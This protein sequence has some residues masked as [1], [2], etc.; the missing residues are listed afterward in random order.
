M[1]FNMKFNAQLFDLIFSQC[2]INKRLFTNLWSLGSRRSSPSSIATLLPTD[3]LDRFTLIRRWCWTKSQS[4]R[5]NYELHHVNL[6][7]IDIG[8]FTFHCEMCFSLSSLNVVFSTHYLQTRQNVIGIEIEMRC[9]Q[10]K[11]YEFSPRVTI[12]MS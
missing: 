1:F 8:F 3:K 6:L 9:S 4:I 11:V 5:S 12:F 2:G 7:F 10:Y